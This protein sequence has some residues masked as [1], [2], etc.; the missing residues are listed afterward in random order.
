VVLEE[1]VGGQVDP[2]ADP[3]LGA[4]VDE[5]EVRVDRGDHGASGVDHQRESAS[6]EAAPVSLEPPGEGLLELAVDDRGV[7]PGLLEDLALLHHPGA[8]AAT[9]RPLPGILAE[10]DARFESLQPRADPI[11]QCPD[12]LLHPLLL[13]LQV[14]VLTHRWPPR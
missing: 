2:A 5:P 4:L 8:P 7:D 6:P 13:G 11:L 10:A 14:L 3:R 9:A 1:V 12:P